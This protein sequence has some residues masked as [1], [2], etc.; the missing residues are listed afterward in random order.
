MTPEQIAAQ[1]AADYQAVRI[2][3]DG[4]VAAVGR[5]LFTTAIYLGCTPWGYDSRFCFESRSLALKRFNEL[6]SEDDVP[7]GYIARR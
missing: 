7:Q 4:S 2:L 6:Q 1:I 3:P 5:L